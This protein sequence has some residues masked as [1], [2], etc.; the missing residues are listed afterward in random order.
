MG[1][2]GTGGIIVSDTPKTLRMTCVIPASLG[3]P[4]LIRR[5]ELAAVAVQEVEDLQVE[6]GMPGWRLRWNATL[7]ET[8]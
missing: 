8:P 2:G 7:G 4:E 3:I 5:L 6:N 1:T